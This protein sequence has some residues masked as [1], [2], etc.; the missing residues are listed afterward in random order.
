MYDMNDVELAQIVWDYMCYEQPLEKSDIIFGLGSDDIRI[1][2]HAA[3]LYHQGYAPRIIFSGDAGVRYRYFD[4]PEAI[5]FRDR[6]V[7]LG[8]PES[9]ILVELDAMN[10][11]DNITKGYAVLH[12]NNLDPQKMILVQKPLMLRRTYATFMKQW[13]GKTK[14]KVIMSAVQLSLSEYVMDPK[15]TFEYTVNV[16]VGDLQRIRE[17]PKLG[18]QIKQDIPHRVWSAYE[19]LVRRGY[20]KRLLS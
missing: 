4:K 5:I 20:D 12:E 17:Y 19:E 13:P 1:A 3:H 14:P 8:V 18:F 16:M 15:Y 9:D 11:G 2:E 7:E 6:A 10:T